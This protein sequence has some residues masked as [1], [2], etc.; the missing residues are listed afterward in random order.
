MNIKGKSTLENFNRILNLKNY[1]DNSS[2][3]YLILKIMQIIL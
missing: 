2:T 3:E 1:A